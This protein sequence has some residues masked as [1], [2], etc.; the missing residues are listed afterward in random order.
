MDSGFQFYSATVNWG[1]GSPLEFSGEPNGTNPFGPNVGIVSRQFSNLFN[2]PAVGDLI[3]GRIEGRHNYA[4]TGQF[5]VTVT[6]TD[7][8]GGTAPTQSTL[9]DVYPYDDGLAISADGVDPYILIP[10]LA[11]VCRQHH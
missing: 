7:S 2:G 11:R 9:V 1:D 3:L 4:T 5:N 8:N 6:L 10:R